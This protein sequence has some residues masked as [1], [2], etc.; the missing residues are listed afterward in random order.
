MPDEVFC[1]LVRLRLHRSCAASGYCACGR[2]HSQSATLGIERRKLRRVGQLCRFLQKRVQCIK[3]RIATIGPAILQGLNCRPLFALPFFLRRPQ[4]KEARE[5]KDAERSSWSHC[6]SH[7]FWNS[8]GVSSRQPPLD[9]W[10]ISHLGALISRG[11][12][13]ALQFDFIV[14]IADGQLSERRVAKLL[15]ASRGKEDKRPNVS[16]GRLLFCYK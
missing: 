13:L 8:G 11:V 3:L 5:Q 12:G 16:S 9:A 10:Y 14:K 15:E 4:R 6:S 7:T 2:L 1:G